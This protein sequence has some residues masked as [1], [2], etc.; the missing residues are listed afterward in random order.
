MRG[1]LVSCALLSA[2]AESLESVK[3]RAAY[4]FKCPVEQITLDDLGGDTIGARGCGQQASY[5][6]VCSADNNLVM[7]SCRWVR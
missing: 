2:C 6:E 1:L 7:Y 5:V 4:D 3:K